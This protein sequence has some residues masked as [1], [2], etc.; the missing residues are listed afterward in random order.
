M[1]L[2]ANTTTPRLQHMAHW[3]GAYLFGKPLQIVLDVASIAAD[4]LVFNY[5]GQSLPAACFQIAPHPLLFE[6]DIRDQKI[7]ISEIDGQVCFFKTGGEFPFD[8]LAASFYLLQRY[9]EYGQHP[10]DMYGRYAH[11][12]SLAWREKFLH[13]PLVDIWMMQLKQALL[14]KFPQLVFK[15]E[16]FTFLPTYDI[17]I[18]YSYKGKGLLRNLFGLYRSTASLQMEEVISRLNVLI[19]GEKDPFDVYDE[20]DQLHQQ[21]GV[22]PIY[23]FL[24][25][26]KQK[27]IDKNT[28]PSKKGY[29]RL[30][31]KLASQYPTGIH[32]SA[33]ASGNEKKLIAEKGILEK[34]SGKSVTA[35]RMHY[36]L[37]HLPETYRQ[38]QNTGLSQEYSMGYGSINGFR[39][40][41]CKPYNWYDLQAEKSTQLQIIPFCYMEANSVFEQRDSPA[42]ALE[43]MQR[44]AHII[45]QVKGCFVTIFHNHLIGY[46]NEGRKWMELYRQFLSKLSSS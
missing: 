30:I 2:F 32:P 1:L 37:F 34:L 44:Y 3:L 5:S 16:A 38:L 25:A 8:V 12:N 23:F 10:K 22:Q 28:S 4:D 41:T 29:Q 14:Q 17:D 36:I 9:E 18:A 46:G 27:G 6:N 40:S 26:Q 42:L 24:L 11:E 19:W 13:Q 33:A 31:K 21:Y 20:L 15:Q 35:S 39:A 7:S 43:E 45:Q